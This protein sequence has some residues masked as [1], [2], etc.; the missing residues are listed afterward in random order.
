MSSPLEARARVCDAR[1]HER[2]KRSTADWSQHAQ[3]AV[4]TDTDD[5]GTPL[6]LHWANCRACNST[7]IREIRK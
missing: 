2:S 1:D 3:L 5:D 7:L 6:E 4:T